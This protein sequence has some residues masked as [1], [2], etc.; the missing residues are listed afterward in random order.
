MA[1]DQTPSNAVQIVP[2]EA[3]HSPVV[4][5]GLST[6]HTASNAMSSGQNAIENSIVD[7]RVFTNKGAASSTNKTAFNAVRH[8]KRHGDHCRCCPDIIQHCH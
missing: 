3:Q 1:D 2:T 4:T 6:S 8:T 7:V 5:S